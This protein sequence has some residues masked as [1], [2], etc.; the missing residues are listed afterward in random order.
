MNKWNCFLHFLFR[1]YDV[2]S[3]SELPEVVKTFIEILRSDAMFLLL[4][5]MTGLTLHEN[6]AAE[7]DALPNGSDTTKRKFMRNSCAHY[8]IIWLVKC[9]KRSSDYYQVDGYII[10]CMEKKKNVHLVKR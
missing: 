5:S 3:E 6:P 2:C 8:Q 9:H 10:I 7:G 1:S 4:S